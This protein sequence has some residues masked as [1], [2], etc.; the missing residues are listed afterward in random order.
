MGGIQRRGDLSH[1]SYGPKAFEPSRRGDGHP[2]VDAL[3][4]PHRDVGHAVLFAGPVDGDYVRVV[5][6]RGEA[7]LSYESLPEALL[8]GQ[9]RRNELQRHGTAKRELDRVIDDTHPAATHDLIDPE[10]R[11]NRARGATGSLGGSFLGTPR[12][13]DCGLSTAG[14]LVPD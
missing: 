5:D 14:V 7:R 12:L 10:I 3:H 1:E 8:V 4:E 2:Q 6:R 11:E 9:V 13:Q